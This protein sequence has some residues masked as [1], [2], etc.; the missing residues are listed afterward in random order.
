MG[1]RVRSTTTTKQWAETITAKVQTIA[2]EL[3]VK[4]FKRTDLNSATPERLQSLNGI[5]VLYAKK[6]VMGRPYQ[7]TDELVTRHILPPDT[8]DR[9]KNQIVVVQP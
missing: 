1:Q 8:Y 6:I 4:G 7:R 5:G 3:G 2:G 9:M